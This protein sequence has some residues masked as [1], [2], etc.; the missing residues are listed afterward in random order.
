MW[1]PNG[2]PGENHEASESS[3]PIPDRRLNQR[4]PGARLWCG[5]FVGTWQTVGRT[6]APVTATKR[7]VFPFLVLLWR[8]NDVTVIHKQA[9]CISLGTVWELWEDSNMA[10]RPEGQLLLLVPEWARAPLCSSTTAPELTLDL[11]RSTH[12]ASAALVLK[13]TILVLSYG[14]F[15]VD[16]DDFQHPFL[17]SWAIS[18]FTILVTWSAYLFPVPSTWPAYH[19]A[20][21]S[22]TIS[23]SCYPPQ[24]H[25]QSQLPGPIT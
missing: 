20:L 8:N 16:I 11:C 15:T 22:R 12:K 6:L 4:M 24:L 5:K 2:G 18:V 3:L 14:T 10:C 25:G 13:R 19:V 23:L 21:S 17:W 9:V 7:S 1:Q